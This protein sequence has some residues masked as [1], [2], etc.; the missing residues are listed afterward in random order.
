MLGAIWKKGITAEL[1]QKKILGQNGTFVS[2]QKLKTFL[3]MF[4]GSK[5]YSIVL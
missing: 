4:P 1:D 5:C 3:N 2:T